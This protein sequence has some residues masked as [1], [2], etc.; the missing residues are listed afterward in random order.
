[1][2]YIPLSARREREV[3]KDPVAGKNRLYLILLTIR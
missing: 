1:M 2:K 3:L